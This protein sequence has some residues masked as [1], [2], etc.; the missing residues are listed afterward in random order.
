[1]F[2]NVYNDHWMGC[3]HIVQY[4]TRH[5]K[6]IGNFKVHLQFGRLLMFFLNVEF[7]F[8]FQYP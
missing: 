2:T 6:S 5:W 1:M 3:V 8:Y 7:E 4:E